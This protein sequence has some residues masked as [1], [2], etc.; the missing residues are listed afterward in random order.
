MENKI[1]QLFSDFIA[2]ESVST[3]SSR[4]KEIL[5]AVEF[6]KKEIK[7]LGFEVNIYQK[8]DYPPLIIAKRNVSSNAKTIGVYAHYDIQPEDPVEQWDSP[9]F[10]L[11]K[12]NGKI[13]GRGVADDKGHII[14][15]LAAIEK[16]IKTDHL[17]NNLLLIFEGEEEVGSQNFEA[18]ISQAK[19][20]FEKVD[21]FYILDMGMKEKNVP[22][23]FYG[24]R[25][26]IAFELKIK[27]S[28]TDLHSGVY[29]NRVLNPAQLLSELLSKI[30]DSQT[31]RIKIPGFYEQV[32]KNQL[33]PSLDING[34]IS[35]YTGEGSKTIIPATAMVKFS[36]R[37]VPDQD[38]Q[39]IEKLTQTFIEKNLPEKIN[40]Q[41]KI[42]SGSDAFYTDFKNLYAEKTA[43]ILS[44]IFNS[45]T[46]FNRSG[47]SIAAAEILQRLFK[48]PVI[49]TGFTLPD[50]K[51]HAPN[52]N[53]DEEMFWKGIESLEKIFAQ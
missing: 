25:G 36:I 42:F 44:K 5:K 53:I 46:Y 3:D 50:E 14:Q 11:T 37:L 48:K 30:K 13:L 47:G 41:L 6:L 40:F 18:L 52:E 4:Q 2:I 49:L 23:I 34:M 19:K 8:D 16:L 28:Q 33:D 12:K 26:V 29:G 32:K 35:G 24:L 10:I 38:H 31:G 21:A 20:D 1:I 15:T 22:Q 39:K 9:P 17:K 51:I 43:E 45:K 7:S 27:T